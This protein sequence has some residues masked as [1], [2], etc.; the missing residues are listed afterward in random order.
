MKRILLVEDD[1]YLSD[2]LHFFITE[3]GHS[4][5]VY[6]SADQ[7]MTNIDKLGE[8]DK[9]I[10]DI[11]MMKGKLIRK[12]DA[13]QETGE[14]LYKELRKRFPEIPV[15]VLSAKDYANMIVDFSDESNVYTLRKPVN[16]DVLREL[17]KL[18]IK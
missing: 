13:D 4:C 3:A 14:F 1:K 12:L 16:E 7:F 11:M 9:I 18:I 5:E 15:I 6:H 10:L 8:F 17:M 2:D